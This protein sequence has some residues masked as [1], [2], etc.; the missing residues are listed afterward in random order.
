MVLFSDLCRGFPNGVHVPGGDYHIGS[1]F[2]EGACDIVAQ[3]SVSACYNGYFAIQPEQLENTSV[4]TVSPP[5][6]IDYYF[7]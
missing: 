3:P 2:R 1:C 6:L 4:H 7:L 5:I